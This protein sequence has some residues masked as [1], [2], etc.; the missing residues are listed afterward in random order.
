MI[1]CWRTGGQI[2]QLFPRRFHLPVIAFARESVNRMKKSER[3]KN[4]FGN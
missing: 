4:I 2:R 3:Q 1:P